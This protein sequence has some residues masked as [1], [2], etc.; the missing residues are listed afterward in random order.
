M[1]VRQTEVDQAVNAHPIFQTIMKIQL[2]NH[3]QKEQKIELKIKDQRD[4]NKQAQQ[5]KAK[6]KMDALKEKYILTTIISTFFNYR[7]IMIP[8]SNS[9][10]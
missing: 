4:K 1:I 10:Y 7:F 5:L 3:V 6:P 9:H 2:K 8:I